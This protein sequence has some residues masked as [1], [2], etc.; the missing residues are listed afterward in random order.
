[1][2]PLVWITRTCPHRARVQQAAMEE[3]STLL[4]SAVAKEEVMDTVVGRQVLRVGQPLAVV[5]HNNPN[6][7]PVP[8]NLQLES[9]PMR[10]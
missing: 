10:T 5:L 3:S 9:Y 8:N 2:R 1:M 7:Q 4:L 6:S